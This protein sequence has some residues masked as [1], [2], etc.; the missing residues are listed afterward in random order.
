MNHFFSLNWEMNNRPKKINQKKLN[1]MPTLLNV[2][3]S[4][5]KDDRYGLV[6]LNRSSLFE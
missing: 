6:N 1:I 4:T 3:H 2:F 5:K